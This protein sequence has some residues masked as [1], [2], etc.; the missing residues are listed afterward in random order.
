MV[1]R[2]PNRGRAAWRTTVWESVDL[3]SLSVGD[4]TR[5]RN[6]LGVAARLPAAGALLATVGWNFRSEFKAARD[7]TLSLRSRSSLQRQASRNDL[8]GASRN[9]FQ[10]QVAT[11]AI[12]WFYAYVG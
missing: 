1:V 3:G 10:R 5:E 8:G 11:G 7:R 9:W 6:W 2:K 4:H 12:N